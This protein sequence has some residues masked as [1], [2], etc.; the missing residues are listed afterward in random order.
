M[1]IDKMLE[2]LKAEREGVEQAILVLAHIAS[3]REKRG[4]VHLSG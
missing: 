1:D 3:G 4:G 2:E